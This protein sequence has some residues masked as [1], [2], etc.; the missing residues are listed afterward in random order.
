MTTRVY[1][2]GLRPPT[3]ETASLVR[4]QLRA[5]HDYANELTSVERGRRWALRQIDDTP[6]VREAILLVKSAKGKTRTAEVTRLREARK[7]ARELAADEL[8]LIA[9]REHELL[10]SARANTQAFWGTYWGVEA[11]HRQSR[12]APLYAED[13]ITPADPKFVR[14]T[15]CDTPKTMRATLPISAEG[16]LGIQIQGGMSVPEF[17]DCRDTRARLQRGGAKDGDPRYGFLSIRV[18]SKNRA[19]I[20]ATWP[21]KISRELPAEGVVKWVRVSVRHEGRREQ[22]SCEIT[23][24]DPAP[25]PRLLDVSLEG[26]IA[27]EWEWSPLDSGEMRVA[28]WMDA[29]GRRG[30]ILLPA[31]ICKGI[32]KPD[33][34]RAVRDMILNDFRERLARAIK[35][36]NGAPRRLVESAN[37]MHLWRS[38]RRFYALEAWWADN[39]STFAPKVF[40]TLREWRKRDEHLWDY[41]SGSRGE[42]LRERR[43]FYRLLASRWA[44]AYKFSLL[45][46]Q[47]LSREARFGAE[48]DARFTAGVSELRNAIRNAFG[49]DALDGKWRAPKDAEDEREWCER[50]CDA[51]SQGGAR[52]ESMFAKRKE[53]TGNAWAD[54]KKRSAEKKVSEETARKAD[55]N[56]AE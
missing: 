28:R 11:A 2:F 15:G 13:A 39:A 16:E 14:W 55:S 42:A 38:P 35:E 17:F 26:A 7:Q 4:A 31:G 25:M 53:Q 27:V 54:R 41:E 29:I 30:E 34:I 48:G 12:Q 45:S 19:P 49:F 9:E 8:K 18:G 32:R 5:A 46:D 23:V 10:L 43:E 37:T 33:G 22:W 50:A 40:S 51:W 20:W 21:V 47:D 6:E 52:S 36:E 3:P 1:R 56:A 44:R 24:A